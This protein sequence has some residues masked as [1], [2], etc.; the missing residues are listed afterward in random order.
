MAR[1]W[2][3]GIRTAAVMLG[4]GIVQPTGAELE[5]RLLARRTVT[6]LSDIRQG[7]ALNATN[8]GLRRPGLGLAPDRLAAV[9][10]RTATRDLPAG[11]KIAE[12]DVR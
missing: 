5:M 11:H 4:D 2:V 1:A 9:L 6:A 8:V 3:D 7:E 12:A 10:G